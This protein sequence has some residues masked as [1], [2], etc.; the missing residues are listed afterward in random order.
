MPIRE[1]KRIWC[2]KCQKFE[3]HQQ[4]YPNWD[5]WFC[6]VCETAYTPIELREIPKEEIIKQ[7]QR[8][9]EWKKNEFEEVLGLMSGLGRRNTLLDMFSEPGSDVK[10]RES[11]AGQKKLDEISKKIRDKKYEEQRQKREEEKAE[12]KKYK[13]LGRN[14][15]CICGSGLKYKKCCL[16][17]IQSYG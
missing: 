6:Q 14:D 2:K 1:L 16:T 11:D 13:H 9:K 10:I 15:L 3:L 4:Y 8:Y 17:K 12:M 7:R 5:D